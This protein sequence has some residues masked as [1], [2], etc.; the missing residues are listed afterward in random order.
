[1]AIGWLTEEQSATNRY[2]Q[3]FWQKN[4]NQHFVVNFIF[5]ISIGFLSGLDFINISPSPSPNPW[6]KYFLSRFYY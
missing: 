3:Q 5:S 4:I 1:L 2:Q 6:Q